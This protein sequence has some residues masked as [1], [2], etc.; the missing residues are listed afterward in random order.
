MKLQ[1]LCSEKGLKSESLKRVAQEMSARLGYHVAR[2]TQEN[3]DPGVL[4][5]RW[6]AAADKLVQYQKFKQ[7]GI[8]SLDFT[9][10]LAQAGV[11]F[12]AGETV[13][14]RQKLSSYE[15]KGIVLFEP[16]VAPSKEEI[17]AC[18]VFTKFIPKEREFRVHSFKGKPVVTLE[19]KMKKDWTGPTSQHIKNTAN[20]YVFCAMDLVISEAL[21]KR[22]NE[23]ATASAKVCASDFQGVDIGYHKAK[24][25]LFVIEVNS[26]PGIEG[27]N[28]GRYCDLI[29][30]YVV[31]TQPKAP[32]I[33][34]PSFQ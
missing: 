31:E 5:L 6:G 15:G 26:A 29:S 18:K 23:L 21:Q 3:Y 25:N 19:K 14:G 4:Q 17:L 1:L 2:V 28:V 7:L 11:W 33:G 32:K 22:I 30:T 13:V 16:H 27:S 20:G 12:N 24:D 9:T 10:H 8:S 34:W